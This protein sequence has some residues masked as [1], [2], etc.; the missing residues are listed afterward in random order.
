MNILSAERVGRITGSRVAGVLGVD[1]YR[2]SDDVLRDMVRQVLGAETE[3]LG[4]PATRYG[5]EHEPDAIAEYERVTG[6]RIVDGQQFT[7]HPDHPFLGVTPDGWIDNMN[8]LVEVK[9]PWRATYTHIAERP[10]Y[11]AQIQLQLACT[12]ADA[13]EFVVWRPDGI[14]LSHVDADPWWLDSI[15]PTLTAFMDT[16]IR[17]IDDPELA[18]PHLTD[19]GAVRDDD[20]W[21]EA[22]VEYLEACMAVDAATAVKDDAKNRLVVLR[23]ASPELPA[24]G[25]GVTLIQNKPRKSVAYRDVVV[26]LVPDADLTPFTKEQAETSWTIRR[27]AV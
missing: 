5:T 18:A 3:F 1:P 13:A 22:A 9:A 12:G 21:A 14:S 11:A 2:T 4:N 7:I 8:W 26:A 25:A 15:M 27:T 23:T 6:N 10:D 19:L 24:K 20:A 17:T 16:Y